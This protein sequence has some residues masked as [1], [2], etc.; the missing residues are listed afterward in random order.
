MLR[1]R[2]NT[3]TTTRIQRDLL[4]EH[5]CDANGLIRY[6][7][8]FWRSVETRVNS[9]KSDFFLL[10]FFFL[11]RSDFFSTLLRR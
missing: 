4:D 2:L 5:K 7:S 1:F 9:K 3:G 8:E 10:T 11:L 6:L